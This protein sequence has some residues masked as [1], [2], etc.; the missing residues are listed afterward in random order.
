MLFHILHFDFFINPIIGLC[1]VFVA[2]YFI[3]KRVESRLQSLPGPTRWPIVGNIPDLAF[4]RQTYRRLLE[5]RDKYGDIVQLRLGP[6]LTVV[7]VFGHKYLYELLVENGDKTKYRPSWLHLPKK[8]FEET[9]VL[10][11]NGEEW[12]SLRKFTINALKELGF[13]STS[14][15]KR[16]QQEAGHLIK[17]IQS[18]GKTETDLKKFIPKAV[19]NIISVIVFGDRFEYTDEDFLELLENLDYIF[20]HFGYQQP[21]I[22]FSFMEPV[23]FSAQIISENMKKIK[24][25]CRKQVKWHEETQKKGVVRDF[26]DMYLEQIGTENGTLSERSM[27]QIIFDLYAAGTETSST[28]LL[29]IALYLI[30]Y[31]V[32]QTKCAAEIK[33]VIGLDTTVQFSDKEKLPYVTATINEVQRIST[34]GALSL[35]RSSLEDVEIDGKVIPKN[36]V[37]IPHIYSAHHDKTEWQKPEEFKPERFIDKD[38]HIIKHKAFYP[39]SIGPRAC[40]GKQLGEMEMFIFTVS[41]LQEFE[42]K[43][44][45]PPDDLDI[46]GLQ[47]G[48]T[49]VPASYK[50][51]VNSRH[52]ITH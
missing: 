29:W 26:V 25:Y 10:W 33:R 42:F 30:K 44:V 24:E 37:I 16:I 3:F 22:F 36:S 49:L 41:L 32:V 4:T 34:L 51:K 7:A 45:I 2:C 43:S 23:D 35:P 20:T 17:A 27:F 13:G 6:N 46:E 40:P 28:G 9:G 12:S 52:K 31:P 19:S 11:S 18:E 5:F 38:R 8:L 14:I 39:F 21:S 1:F 15:E 50:V 47:T 48:V